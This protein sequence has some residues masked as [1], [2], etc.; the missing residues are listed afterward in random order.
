MKFWGDV[1]PHQNKQP[2]SIDQLVLIVSNNGHWPASFIKQPASFMK[3]EGWFY[4]KTGL[5]SAHLF[6]SIVV[7]IGSAYLQSLKYLLLY[8]L[9]DVKWSY[10]CIIVNIKI[11]FF[12]HPLTIPYASKMKCH[13]WDTILALVLDTCIWYKCC[14]WCSLHLTA[15]SCI[16]LV[17]FLTMLVC[18]T[19]YS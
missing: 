3:R 19:V 9:W 6:A 2:A 1:T 5:N 13:P 12:G 4:W 7:K 11:T 16:N 8:I 14:I 10:C 15:I 17:I 18:L